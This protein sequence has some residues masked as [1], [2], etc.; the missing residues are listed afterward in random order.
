MWMDMK[1]PHTE[2]HICQIPKEQ[3]LSCRKDRITH[4]YCEYKNWNKHS[5][6]DRSH[7]RTEYIKCQGPNSNLT[8]GPQGLAKGPNRN[9]LLQKKYRACG[10][11]VELQK[12]P[13]IGFTKGSIFA[14]FK[15]FVT[16][17]SRG[18]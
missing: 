15:G 14:Q 1:T 16:V 7:F 2:V 18:K 4:T 5:F 6:N 17:E 8:K 10:S 13:K 3:I 9:N 12:G 11:N